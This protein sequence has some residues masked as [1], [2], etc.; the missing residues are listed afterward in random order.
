MQLEIDDNKTVGDLQDKFNECFPCLRINFFSRAHSWHGRSLSKDN[1]PANVTIGNITK[2]HQHGPL[3]I[4]STQRA[5]DVER[6]FKQQFG[7]FVQVCYQLNDK[8]IE[9]KDT[10]DFTL[11]QLCCMAEKEGVKY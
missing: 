8:W 4:L 11:E 1:I 2:K 5:G 10:D 3:V 9:T 6:A 7:L